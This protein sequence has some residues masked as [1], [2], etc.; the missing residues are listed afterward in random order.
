MA[1]TLILKKMG[2][3]FFKN[4]TSTSVSDVGNYRVR[5]AFRD[6]KGDAVHGDFCRLPKNNALATD[7][8][9]GYSRYII[10]EAINYDYTRAGILALVNSVSAVHYDDVKIV[11]EW[12]EITSEDAKAGQVYAFCAHWQY[13]TKVWTLTDEEMAENDLCCRTRVECIDFNGKRS[14]YGL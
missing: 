3:D 10:R 12:P 14:S 2:C 9:V 6:K 1:N 8:Q 11:D 7:L 4:D 5:T 13:V